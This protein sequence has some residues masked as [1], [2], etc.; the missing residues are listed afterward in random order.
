MRSAVAKQISM[1]WECAGTM[2]KA[3]TKQNSTIR[4]KRPALMRPPPWREQNLLGSEPYIL[5][6]A[7]RAGNPELLERG[8]EIG[9]LRIGM[10]RRW[11]EA[12]ALH[13][14]RHRRAIDGQH[15]AVDWIPLTGTM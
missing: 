10:N 12:R 9:D 2:L 1:S 14:A 11:R 8:D 3:I 13:A 15:V 4:M 5:A 7:D 6:L